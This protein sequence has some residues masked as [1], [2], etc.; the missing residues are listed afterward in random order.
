MNR[1]EDEDDLLCLK[2]DHINVNLFLDTYSANTIKI[3]V[4]E[5]RMNYNEM[6][7]RQNNNPWSIPHISVLRKPR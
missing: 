2:K 4:N 6:S 3:S 7:I 1:E 5:M